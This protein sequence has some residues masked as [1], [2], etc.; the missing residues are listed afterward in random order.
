MQNCARRA[1]L[2]VMD[3]DDDDTPLSALRANLIVDGPG[4][5]VGEL[6]ERRNA[7]WDSDED[8]PLSALR[9]AV[10]ESRQTSS[11][12]DRQHT[13]AA[14]PG[15][16]AER[17]YHAPA[18]SAPGPDTL[19][20]ATTSSLRAN[21]AAADEDE[22]DDA[23]LSM[24]RCRLL[25]IPSRQRAE[26]PLPRDTAT[27]IAVPSNGAAATVTVEW[28]DELP[29]SVMR[30]MIRAEVAR[31]RAA[32]LLRPEGSPGQSGTGPAGSADGETDDAHT[33][34]RGAEA[35][36]A[37]VEA[38]SKRRRSHVGALADA[39]EHCSARCAVN[40]MARRDGPVVTLH[41]RSE[42]GEVR[43]VRPTDQA[44]LGNWVGR[45]LLQ[46]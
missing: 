14:A 42:S 5:L 35:D 1:F 34:R 20:S 36:P 10:L 44:D 32:L 33:R 21:A 8:I 11:P 40:G 3:S 12:Y 2:K 41:S 19:V 16:V 6:D 27:A 15:V 17:G 25:N 9:H 45:M 13:L 23:P 39:E 30:A 46:V 7:A 38:R 43:R 29:L 24:L 37:D 31:R 4:R 18:V 22:S 28:D 26:S